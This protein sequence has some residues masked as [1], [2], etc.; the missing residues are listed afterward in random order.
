MEDDPIE[1][2]EPISREEWQLRFEKYQQFS[3]ALP[4]GVDADALYA[5]GLTPYEAYCQSRANPH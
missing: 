2:A 4:E 5:Q 1:P 3:G